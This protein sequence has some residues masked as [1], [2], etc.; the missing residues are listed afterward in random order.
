MVIGNQRH[1]VHLPHYELLT[2]YGI[3]FKLWPLVRSLCLSLARRYTLPIIQN[4]SREAANLVRIRGGIAKEPAK[5]I[6]N[7]TGNRS[8]N[9]LV[10]LLASRRRTYELTYHAGSRIPTKIA[11]HQ[12][13]S[14]GLLGQMP[15]YLVGIATQ[16]DVHLV[17]PQTQQL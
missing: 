11:C 13:Y 10:L 7:K 5:D 9:S 3:T 12:D 2:N 4:R 15:S 17:I 16:T 8:G 6:L 1:A 14:H